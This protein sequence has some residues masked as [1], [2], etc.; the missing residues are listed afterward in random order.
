[1]RQP[2]SNAK[3]SLNEHRVQR[4]DLVLDMKI[5]AWNCQ[6]AFRKKADRIAGYR[7]DLAVISE[8]EHPDKLDFAHDIEAPSTAVWFGDN[9][10]KGIGVFSYT[11]AKFKLHK[12]YSPSIR[13][14]I[15]IRV[16]GALTFNLLAI[17]AMPNQQNGKL[18]Y[19]GQV[20]QAVEKYRRF[21]GQRDTVLIGDW[22]SNKLWDRTHR[23]G[24][25]SQVV[26]KLADR[27]IVSV[28]HQYFGEDQGKEKINTLYMQRKRKKGFHVDYCFVP[29]TWMNRLVAFSIGSFD[30]WSALSDHSPIFAEFGP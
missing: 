5:V 29:R 30:D 22:N 27:N 8:C 26:A 23:I 18:G 12:N 1:L 7:P 13:Y 11:G 25:H 17:W 15:P 28:Y 6:G 19:I 2:G 4:Q 24:N 3:R 20:Y 16:T 14:C 9:K 21:I 10:A